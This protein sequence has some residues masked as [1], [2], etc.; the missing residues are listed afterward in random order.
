MRLAVPCAAV[1]VVG[2][3]AACSSAP[4]PRE[5][6]GTTS[7]AVDM[8]CGK[9]AAATLDGFPAY[10]YCGNFNVYT[11]NGI[12]TRGTGGAGWTQTEGG[13]GYQC[14]E[15]AVRYFYFKWNVPHGWFVS[16]AKDMCTTY[17]A[18]VSKTTTP[19]HGDL[20][21]FG[22]GSCGADPTAGHVAAINSVGASTISVVQQNPA[23]T[24]TWN[25][26]CVM[27]YLHASANGAVM[28]PCSTAPVNGLYCGQSPQWGGGQTDVLYDCEGGV[29]KTKTP[30]PYGCQLEPKNTNDKCK[31]A[32]PDAGSDAAPDGAPGDAAHESGG[33]PPGNDAA[34]S[35]GDDAGWGNDSG[36]TGGS[37][38]CDIG[39]GR[40]P[41]NGFALLAVTVAALLARK[42]R[43]PP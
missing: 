1:V 32:P 8:I 23:G 16:Y 40:G 9:P 35:P 21:V 12:D 20:A 25:K 41:S 30:C 31:A 19:V 4:E 34:P 28:D 38:G 3:A 15:W 26:S 7:E 5:S 42:R 36:N 13:Y 17:P 29:T 14:V 43:A 11:D 24:D 10:P 2:L 6:V 18:T 37:G 22:P 39:S 27:C 33:L